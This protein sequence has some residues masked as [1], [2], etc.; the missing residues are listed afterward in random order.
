M[1]YAGDNGQGGPAS[2]RGS[3]EK[4][5]FAKKE[6]SSPE[7]GKS[8]HEFTR[9]EQRWKS[10]IPSGENAAREGR[11]GEKGHNKSQHNSMSLSGI[12]EEK[13]E[14]SKAEGR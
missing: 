11:K 8:E 14:E 4:S 9:G 1:H 6:L 5:D 2:I 7:K 12:R 10:Q 3:S 13:Y